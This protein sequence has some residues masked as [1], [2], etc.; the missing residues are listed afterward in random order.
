MDEVEEESQQSESQND[1][2]NMLNQD[3]HAYQ[4]VSMLS[5]EIN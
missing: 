1:L 5:A 4:N 2:S 3:N